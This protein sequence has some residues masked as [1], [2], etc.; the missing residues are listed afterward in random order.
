MP[1]VP[2]LGI[3][4]TS[5]ARAVVLKSQPRSSNVEKQCSF[6]RTSA[7]FKP[8]VNKHALNLPRDN[9]RGTTPHLELE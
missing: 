3:S 4:P 9:H 7:V 6:R 5:Q 2:G 1:L 8:S